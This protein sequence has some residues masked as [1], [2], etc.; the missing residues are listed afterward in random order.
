MARPKGVTFQSPRQ[1]RVAVARLINS[2]RD[3]SLDMDVNELK[4]LVWSYSQLLSA[5]KLEKD[6]KIEDDIVEIKR[7][8]DAKG[9]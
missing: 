4:S 1:V 7:R 9:L 2:Y 8:L 5:L 6:F 3:G